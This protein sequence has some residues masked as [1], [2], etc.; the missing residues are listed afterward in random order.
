MPYVL[1][2][3]DVVYLD[4]AGTSGFRNSAADSYKVDPAD[5]DRHL[6]AIA[7]TGRQVGLCLPGRPLPEVAITFDD[8]GAS[9]LRAADALERRGWRGHFFVTTAQV[10]QSGFLDHQGVRELADRG[11]AIGSHSHTHPTYF[12]RLS[13]E[14]LDREWTESGAMLGELLGSRPPTASIP[15]GF[16]SD[17]A[18]ESAAAAGYEVLMTSEPSSRARTAAGITVL[19]RYAIRS[20]TSAETVAAYARGARGPRARMWLEWN[21]KQRAKRISPRAFE[22]LRTRLPG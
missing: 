12:G 10:G 1:M 21:A 3:H 16:L 19:G 8:G 14:E 2:Y 11:H 15:G 4:S 9:S 6:D 5:F 13:R 7:D 18:I 22:A 17:E 20:R